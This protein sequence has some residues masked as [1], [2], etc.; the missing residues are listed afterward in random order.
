MCNI[1]SSKRDAELWPDGRV[2]LHL[3]VHSLVQVPLDLVERL[4]PPNP[5]RSDPPG[6]AD[7]GKLPPATSQSSRGG[8]AQDRAVG[9]GSD[10]GHAD[11][12]LSPQVDVERR[13]SAPSDSAGSDAAGGQGESQL[14]P[15]AEVWPPILAAATSESEEDTKGAGEPGKPLPPVIAPAIVDTKPLGPSEKSAVPA[16]QL[17]IGSSARSTSDGKQTAASQANSS[18]LAPIDGVGHASPDEPAPVQTAADARSA[19]ND[20]AT[21][22]LVSDTHSSGRGV[23]ATEA[24]GLVG[25]GTVGMRA[26]GQGL[27]EAQHRRLLTHA[28]PWPGVR[29]A[30]EAASEEQAALQTDLE[31]S[32]SAQQHRHHPS[33]Q[34]QHR[35]L[36]ADVDFSGSGTPSSSLPQKSTGSGAAQRVPKVIFRTDGPQELARGTPSP[37]EDIKLFQH[38]NRCAP[39]RL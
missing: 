11:V 32:Y 21:L 15:Q 3:L 24:N 23:G 33:E 12:R 6:S 25:W 8:S 13:A 16:A 35:Q 34:T 4:L 1:D 30:A 17:A 37:E 29:S 22:Q 28:A 10:D 36:V 5:A 27:P 18:R 31:A 9:G 19:D 20:A 14:S 7:H 2:D 39:T 38:I 26:A